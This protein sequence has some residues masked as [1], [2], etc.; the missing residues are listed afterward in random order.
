MYKFKSEC[1][2]HKKAIS[3][4]KFS[5]D[6][7]VL[8]SASADCLAVAHDATTGA[9]KCTLDGKHRQ[10]LNDVIWMG[11]THLITCGDDRSIVIW[12]VE[13]RALIGSLL[14]HKV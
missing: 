2:P 7:R 10:G 3:A 5:P 14:G 13:K 8:A 9:Y 11:N 12:D 6:G 4:V 1:T